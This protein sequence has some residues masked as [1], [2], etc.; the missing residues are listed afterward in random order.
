MKKLSAPFP[1]V[2]RTSKE[3]VSFASAGVY[4]FETV[5]VAESTVAENSGGVRNIIG[6]LF[7][8]KSP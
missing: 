6:R 4:N 8:D 5:R 7:T 2:T 3:S 1:T